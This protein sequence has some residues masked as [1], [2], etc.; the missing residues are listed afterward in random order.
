M[1]V[2][3]IGFVSM[4]AARMSVDVVLEGS[5][6]GEKL[7]SMN[8]QLS[9]PSLSARENYTSQVKNMTGHL[10]TRIEN[11]FPLKKE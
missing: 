5:A 6:N 8:S 4:P 2:T 9:T 7:W 3:G 1:A 10:K 11:K